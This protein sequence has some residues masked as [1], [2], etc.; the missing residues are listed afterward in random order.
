MRR[1]DLR[2]KSS[3]RRSLTTTCWCHAGRNLRP[4]VSTIIQIIRTIRTDP[5]QFPS[6]ALYTL[7]VLARHFRKRQFPAFSLRY[8]KGCLARIGWISIK[9]PVHL[10]PNLVCSATAR[11]SRNVNLLTQSTCQY[12]HTSAVTILNFLLLANL[13]WVASNIF[14]LLS[15]R[16]NNLHSFLHLTPLW[17]KI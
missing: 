10:S 8:A 13:T 5:S 1:F 4:Y 3:R 16:C 9:G 11:L 2:E 14:L 12:S 15:S 6:R 7:K 17:L